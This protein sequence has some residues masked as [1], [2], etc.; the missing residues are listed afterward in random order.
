MTENQLMVQK[1]EDRPTTLFKPVA[2][3]A[4]L[5]EFHAAVTEIIT[6]W[7]ERDTDY[8]VIPGAKKPTLLKPGAEKL[9]KAFNAS[10][11]FEV[12]SSDVDHDRVNKY[13]KKTWANGRPAGEVELTSIGHY[14]YVVRCV[15]SINGKEVGDAIASCS[16]LE[17][18][19]I[20]R[21]RDVE[22]TI[23]KMACKRALVA[24]VSTTFGLSDRFTQ[25]LEDMPPQKSGGY[26]EHDSQ[27]YVSAGVTTAFD[28]TN[29]NHIDRLITVLER[30]TP[31]VPKDLWD[32][33]ALAMHGKPMTM[34]EMQNV[35]AESRS[36]L[37]QVGQADEGTK[38]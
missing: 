1:V 15:L 9:C 2:S 25:D 12:V 38:T 36:K 22:N 20:D 29:K 16:S 13:S 30:Q 11:R 18:K 33:I 8:G 14:R 3:V 37:A 32:N 24:A 27:R 31:S 17:S 4:Q 5:L 35:V 21:P 34:S 26:R 7:L 28:Q 23:L 6:R 10:P 19:Y